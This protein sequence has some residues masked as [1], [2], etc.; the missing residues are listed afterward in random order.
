MPRP[1]ANF[2]HTVENF[3]LHRGKI[4]PTP[5]A[6]HVAT[7]EMASSL[8][9]RCAQH[10]AVRKRISQNEGLLRQNKRSDFLE[11]ARCGRPEQYSCTRV[12]D[13][14]APEQ[15]RRAFVLTPRFVKSFSAS[16]STCHLPTTRFT[17]TTPRII[18]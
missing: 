2:F 9:A 15:K 14:D 18:P 7:R 6:Q 11:M 5:R 10:V 17:T 12:G 13:L 16:P 1:A 3:F 8:L 4:P